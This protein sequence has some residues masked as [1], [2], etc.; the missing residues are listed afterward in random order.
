MQVTTTTKAEGDATRRGSSGSGAASGAGGS[1]EVGVPAPS[2]VTPAAR[3][4]HGAPT[5]T[6]PT[7]TA[8]RTKVPC[9]VVEDVRVNRTMLCRALA[10]KGFEPIGA[11]DGQQALDLAP[12]VFGHFERE[13]RGGNEGGPHELLGLVVMDRSMPIMGGIECTNKLRDMFGDRLAIIGL[14]GD[15]MQED[16]EEFKSA[17]LDGVMSKPAGAKQIKKMWDRLSSD[18]A[19]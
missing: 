3:P 12:A 18:A 17:G 2:F 19:R 11:E 15:A 14:T 9:L 6:K 1:D 7:A 4:N 13:G 16:L 10:R 8:S 5:P